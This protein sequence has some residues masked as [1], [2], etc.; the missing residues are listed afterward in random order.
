VFRAPLLYFCISAL[1]YLCKSAL[2]RFCACVHPFA[3]QL[4][5]PVRINRSR[6]PTRT[7]LRTCSLEHSLTA[8]TDHAN[9][10]A[11][12][13]GLVFVQLRTRDHSRA[14]VPQL[15]HSF[16]FPHSTTRGRTHSRTHTT[17]HTHATER[18]H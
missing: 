13:P 3:L 17:P 5:W 10:A 12:Y 15:S 11:L 2:L 9:Y 16:A 7:Q 4:I 1:M 14:G 6:T 18:N 8:S